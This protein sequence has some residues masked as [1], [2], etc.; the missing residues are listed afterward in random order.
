[1]FTTIVQI[2]CTLLTYNV[3][4]LALVL[5]VFVCERVRSLLAS[6]NSELRLYILNVLEAA[7]CSIQ[8]FRSLYIQ[9]VRV[10]VNRTLK[11]VSDL[12]YFVK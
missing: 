11:T 8:M 5:L 4:K 9:L 10:F 2:Y 7:S 12:K 3:F 6:T 1:M